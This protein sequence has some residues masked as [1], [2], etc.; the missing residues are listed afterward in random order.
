MFLS[1]CGLRQ[2]RPADGQGRD[3]RHLP[4]AAQ[5]QPRQHRPRSTGLDPRPL[6]P[7]RLTVRLTGSPDRA[8]PDRPGATCPGPAGP[9]ARSCWRS[10]S[11]GP[12]WPPAWSTGPGRILVRGPGARP[13]TPTDPEEVFDA[14]VGRRDRQVR[15]AA[16]A[17]PGGLRRRVRRA[18]GRRTARRC[19]A[20]HPGLARLPLRARLADQVGL[21]VAVDNDAKA[22]ALGE[23]WLGARPGVDRLPGHG[24]V[25]RGR[26][27]HRA[28]RP[29]ARRV[30]RATPATSATWSSSPTAGR[31]RAGPG[32]S[33]GRGVRARPSRRSPAARRRRRAEAV[34][35]RTGTLV[36][37]AVAS[38]A[39]LLD[40]EL[41][42]VAGSVA[43]GFGDAVLRRRPGGDRRAVPSRLLRGRPAIVPAGLGADGPLV[44]AA[45]VGRRAG[46]PAIGRRSDP[47]TE[48]A[49]ADAARR[50][51]DRAV[52]A[53]PSG[54]ALV[55]PARSLVDRPRRC[56]GGWR[57]PRWWRS[58]PHLPAARRPRCGR[59]G[60]RP[61]TGAP[62]PVPDPR[63][64]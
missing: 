63:A 15:S 13:R 18:D 60:W 35:R 11:A 62:T 54:A 20:Q 50:P 29:A 22:L 24:G 23:G 12:R 16:T 21:P 36:G 37:R 40:L 51:S 14:L 47:M 52:T 7:R 56:S 64:T 28:R 8:W 34:R 49:G 32:L 48:D 26:R 44:G 6:P 46:S 30:G 3:R 39:N 42:V 38:V 53:V 2:Q 61:P 55:R 5:P 58:R 10:T 27:R 4:L 45:A 43:L 57:A 59:S 9:A 41:A 17:E 33:R 25:H 31:A 19:P 1:G